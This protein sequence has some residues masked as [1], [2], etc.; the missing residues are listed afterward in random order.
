VVPVGCLVPLVCCCGGPALIGVGAMAGIKAS[1]P[2]KDAVAR[3]QRNPAV[4]DAIGTPIQVGF[5]VQGTLKVETADGEADLTIPLSGPK[6]LGSLHVVGTKAAGK[7]TYTTIEVDVP[8]SGA[9]INLLGA[10]EGP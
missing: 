6:G 5:L 1:E 2:Y 3:A 9:H 10:E 4:Q 7:W 8:A